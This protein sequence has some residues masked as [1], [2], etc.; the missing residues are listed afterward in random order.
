[1][2]ANNTFSYELLYLVY[3]TTGSN[4]GESVLH[5]MLTNQRK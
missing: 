3:L 1:M 5:D 2:R 4:E